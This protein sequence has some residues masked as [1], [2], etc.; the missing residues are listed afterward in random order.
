M[1]SASREQACVASKNWAV[2]KC[3]ALAIAHYNSSLVMNT[4]LILVGSMGKP[5]ACLQ[6]YTN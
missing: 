4:Y 3:A 2:L 6:P 5:Y 1:P